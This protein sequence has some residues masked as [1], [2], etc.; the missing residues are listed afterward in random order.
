[1]IFVPYF[2]YKLILGYDP[3][4]VEAML[5]ALGPIGLIGGSIYS[6]L[7]TENKIIALKK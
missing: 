5:P 7:K 2:A 1:M 3:D 6:K 4:P